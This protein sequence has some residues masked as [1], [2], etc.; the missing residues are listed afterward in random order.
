MTKQ[1]FI[2]LADTLKALRPDR[3]NRYAPRGVRTKG[4]AA[5]DQWQETIDALADFC[6]SQNPHFNR[7]RWI[8]YINGECGPNGGQ[9]K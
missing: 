3:G 2:A 9:I 8:S 7:D 6:A 5:F 4:E 1:H